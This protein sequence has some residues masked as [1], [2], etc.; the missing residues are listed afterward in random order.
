[1]MSTTNCYAMILAK[2]DCIWIGKQRLFLTT[3]INCQSTNFDTTKT[4]E[5]FNFNSLN[6]T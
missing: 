2:M 1:M 4:I 3:Q 5:I 6:D